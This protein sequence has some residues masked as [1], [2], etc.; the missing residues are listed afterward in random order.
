MVKTRRIVEILTFLELLTK[1]CK[2]EDNVNKQR[3]DNNIENNN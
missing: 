2:M 3:I 1:L